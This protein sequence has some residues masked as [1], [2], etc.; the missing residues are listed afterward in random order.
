MIDFRKGF[1]S[2][3]LLPENI[4]DISWEEFKKQKKSYLGYGAN[5]GDEGFRKALATFLTKNYTYN[6]NPNTLLMTAGASQALDFIC[7]LYTKTGD[8]VFVEEPTYFL[9]FPI[10]RDHKLNIVPIKMQHDGIDISDLKKK[11]QLYKPQF[12]YTIPIFHN[13]SGVTLSH[14]KRQE[15]IELSHF[16][17]FYIIADEVY[18]LLNYENQKVQ[19]FSSYDKYKKVFSLG[20]FTKIL[21]PGVRLGWIEASE[22]LLKP[23]I[24]SGLLNSGGGIAH[25]TTGILKYLLKSDLQQKHLDKLLATYGER[26]K[27]ITEVLEKELPENVTF[28]KPEEA[29]YVDKTS[30]K[31]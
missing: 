20:S 24:K 8:T 6:I 22:K 29:F 14:E 21:T 30:R 11:I 31:T 15:L 4:L 26:A 13:P 18:H 23:F 17:N 19:I 1:P 12:F 16:H 3:D 27:K 7:T 2:N 5:E 9:A 25:F 28:Q 10:F